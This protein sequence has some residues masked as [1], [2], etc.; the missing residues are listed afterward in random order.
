MR[1]RFLRPFFYAFL[2]FLMTACV[3]AP[4][5]DAVSIL[6]PVVN[7]EGTLVAFSFS[8]NATYNYKI[9][10]VS[11]NASQNPTL[12]DL[13]LPPSLHWY[14][15]LWAK[16]SKSLYLLSYCESDICYQGIDGYAIWQVNLLNPDSDKNLTL[17]S[18]R[19]PDRSV[20]D[21]A[22]GS[23][24]DLL[25]VEQKK[26]PVAGDIAEATNNNELPGGFYVTHHS[27]GTGK[28]RI[29][30][31]PRT[32]N[33]KLDQKY[34]THHF[35]HLMLPQYAND[36][37]LHAVGIH[38]YLASKEVRQETENAGNAASYFLYE[39]REKKYQFLEKS[40]NSLTSNTAGNLFLL[41]SSYPNGVVLQTVSTIDS[42]N[43]AALVF[44][45]DERMLATDL[46]VSRDTDVFVAKTKRIGVDWDIAVFKA[47]AYKPVWL[48]MQHRLTKFVAEK[49]LEEAA[50]Q[51][52]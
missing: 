22:L 28:E 15:P 50:Q 17:I 47:G 6:S 14:S 36:N 20:S 44:S 26:F 4:E 32:Y 23:N 9:G 7:P 52:Y 46:S 37:S 1:D 11:T 8:D 30:S 3:R 27:I 41:Q 45:M 5:K 33:T 19:K 29:L 13:A 31:G 42:N 40:G 25:I 49:R 10:I 2:A 51:S 18:Q 34:L 12:L 21:I 16:N 24:D 38:G 39:L 48:N 43:R 35:R